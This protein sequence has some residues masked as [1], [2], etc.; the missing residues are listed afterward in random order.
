MTP[1]FARTGAPA[2]RDLRRIIRFRIKQATGF[3]ANSRCDK[4]QAG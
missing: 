2:E 3:Q 1:W 4:R